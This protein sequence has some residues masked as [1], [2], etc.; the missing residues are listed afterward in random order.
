MIELK[1]YFDS[2]LENLTNDRKKIAYLQLP[3]KLENF[4]VKEFCYFIYTKS[5]G[6]HAAVVN[7]GSK[8]EKKLDIC[9]IRG[10]DLNR[11]DIEILSMIEVKY[12]R[13]WHRFLPYN[14]KD[15]IREL[16]KAFNKQ[17]YLV[18]KSTHGW[19]R[20]NSEVTRVNAIAFASFVSYERNDMTKEGYFTRIL[21]VAREI[22]ADNIISKFS[23]QN[24]HDDTEI[25]LFGKRI[26]ISLRAGL[27]E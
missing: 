12:F 20:I 9:I 21:D 23:F 14:A 7:L 17:I 25:E 8:K 13:N 2:F 27:W 26:Y 3:G 15:N 1:D 11:E 16:M 10:Q 24:V 6:S 5:K 19:F 18:N 4:L 22:F